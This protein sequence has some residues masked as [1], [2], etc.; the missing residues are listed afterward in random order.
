MFSL[1][2]EWTHSGR[3]EMSGGSNWR[4]T[5]SGTEGRPNAFQINLGYISQW[6]YSVIKSIHVQIR[7]TLVLSCII[8][9]SQSPHTIS[10]RRK[11]GTGIVSKQSDWLHSEDHWMPWCNYSLISLPNEP[12]TESI[13]HQRE[14]TRLFHSIRCI[15]AVL[16]NI[17]IFTKIDGKHGR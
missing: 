2:W 13:F 17:F 7:D 6:N 5:F 1:C 16:L 14:I 8:T 15:W 11:I 4:I 9:W 10:A 3:I 12:M